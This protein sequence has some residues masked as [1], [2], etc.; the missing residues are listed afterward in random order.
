MRS[1]MIQTVRRIR[2]NGLAH[3]PTW[4]S[5]CMIHHTFVYIRPSWGLLRLGTPGWAGPGPTPQK[6]PPHSNIYTCRVYHACAGPFWRMRQSILANAPV[7]FIKCACLFWRM[8]YL[9]CFFM[10]IV[11]ICMFFVCFNGLVC[12]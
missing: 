1:I 4:T 5:A 9:S 8:S 6:P 12:L 11:S 7:H 3:S 2:K 10:Q